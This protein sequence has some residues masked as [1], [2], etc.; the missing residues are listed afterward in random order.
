M[1]HV[2]ETKEDFLYF[3]Q[4]LIQQNEMFEKLKY[5]DSDKGERIK[6]FPTA[7]KGCHNGPM[8]K[9]CSG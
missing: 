2:R 1:F 8:H 7:I 3:A 9:T 5:L 6:R 4:T